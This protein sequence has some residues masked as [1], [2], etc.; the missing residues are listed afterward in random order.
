MLLFGV[1]EAEVVG[2]ERGKK[3]RD[4]IFNVDEATS[5]I[6]ETGI[7]FVIQIKIK[8]NEIKESRK[9]K[10]RKENLSKIK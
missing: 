9:E 3:E 5:S 7:N 4:D 8:W 6:C 1:Q 10:K 2:R